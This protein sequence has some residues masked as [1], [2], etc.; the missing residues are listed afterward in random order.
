[1]IINDER[2]VIY[3]IRHGQSTVNINS[4]LKIGGRS[5]HAELTDHGVLQAQKLGEYFTVK[6]IPID[7]IYSSTFIRAIQTADIFADNIGKPVSDIL[8]REEL[9]E[10]DQGKWE[11]KFR[12][13]VYTPEVF[14]QILSQQNYFIPPGG[15]S[16]AKVIHRL[17]GWLL[18]EILVEENLNKHI[19]VV[20]H[21]FAIKCLLQYIMGFNDSMI[22]NLNTENTSVCKL[23]FSS[24]GWGVDYL[25]STS[26]LD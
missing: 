11:G 22:Y 23:I 26:H 8:R 25:N 4:S 6:N 20:F 12:N 9:V 13:E 2:I 16:K 21:G 14:N 1:V 17:S 10:M 5:E 15:E 3:L 19:A 7:T 18:E 24:R